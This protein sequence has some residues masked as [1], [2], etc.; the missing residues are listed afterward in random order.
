MVIKKALY[1]NIDNAIK[2]KALDNITHSNAIQKAAA[3]IN[4]GG[5]V[6]F[7][8]KCLYGLAADALNPEAV[9]RVFHIKQRPLTNPLLVLIDDV[10]QLDSLV[11]P[12]S[13]NIGSFAA[14]ALME[15]FWPGNITLVFHAAP[16]LPEALTAGTG[17]IGIRMPGHPVARALVR[18]VGRPITG[19]SANISGKPGCN[20][21]SQLD[22]EI[23]SKVDMVL[24]HGIL[25]G[26]MG[27]TVVDV[28][29]AP[30]K[31]IRQGEIGSHDILKITI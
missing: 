20:Q 2:K 18:Q 1:D 11:M 27:S 25:K 17:K 24:D 12:V 9:E 15:R 31:I 19:T 23:L 29:C 10:C 26:G 5:V 16:N 28:T 7:P 14:I 4:A 22:P 8:A 21:I 30:V 13:D 3:I 6:V